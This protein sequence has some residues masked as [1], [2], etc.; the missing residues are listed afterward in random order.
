VALV[1]AI[2]A[3]LSIGIRAAQ[4]PAAQPVSA[5]TTVFAADRAMRDVRA[6]AMRPHPTGSADNDRVRTYLAGRLRALG[7]VPEE[8]RYL[9]DPAGYRTLHRW[10]PKTSLASEIVDL[11]GVLPGR[12]HTLPAVAVMAHI[13]TVWGS[14]GGAD[15]SAGVAATLE[16]LRAIR[17]K[18]IPARDVVVLLTD[19]EEI[20]LSGARAFWP[21]DGV[22]S[23]VG[24]VVNLESRGAGGRATM[25]ETGAR[26]AEMIGL[27]A[28]SVAHPIADSM[29]VLAYRLMPNNTD[30]TVPREKGLPGFNFAMLGRPQYY[31]S[32]RATADRLDPRTLQDMGDQA[33]ATIS[34][35]AFAPALPAATHDAVFFDV[36]GHGLVHYAI[37]TGWLI[38]LAAAAALGAAY[39]AIARRGTAVRGE[40]L[41]GIGAAL[42]LPVHAGL[43][44]MAFNLLSGSGQ[45]SNY[46]DRLAALPML[47]SQAT[48]LGI[49]ALLAFFMLRRSEMR[50]L[51]ILP[52]LL[53]ALLGWKLGGPH[54]PI[55]IGAVIGMALGWFAPP[56]GV[57]RWGGWLGAIALVLLV[58]VGL[59][60]GAP[61]AAW[62]FAWPA[63]VFGIAA[64]TVAWTDPALVRPGSA[65]VMAVAAIVVGAPLL[66]LA[67]LAFLGIGAPLAS[68]FAPLLSL[69]AAAFWPLAKIER[70]HRTALVAIALL[71][72]VAFD[73]ARDVRSAPLAPTVPA[74]ALDR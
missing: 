50:I 51:G 65:A 5:P 11:V 24:V 57:T 7:I 9:I 33:L 60:L 30:F 42:W 53:L 58:A 27:F 1:V 15:D 36:A 39:V 32:P 44:L 22:A 12:D 3:I 35:L 37:G 6:M 40:M 70:S 4:P 34:A 48:L 23:H 13:D 69:V 61:L 47:E 71:L 67:H 68:A 2:V 14:P 28:R 63:L 41:R 66:T 62:V 8:R 20:G 49:A 31:H 73:V 46:Y 43:A 59:Q 21:A 45:R 29:A 38:L 19:G 56:G 26:N 10:N 54:A 16:L 18:G 52:A 25:F 64:A 72:I 17:A 55:L 74:Y